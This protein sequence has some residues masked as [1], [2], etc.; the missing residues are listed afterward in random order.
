MEE[1]NNKETK[2]SKS[3]DVHQGTT[4]FIRNLSFATTSTEL[5]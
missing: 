4:L 1:D 3:S 5:S 2:L